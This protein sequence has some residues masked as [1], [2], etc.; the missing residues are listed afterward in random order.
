[1]GVSLVLHVLGS[2]V[3]I[4]SVC[5]SVLPVAVVDAVKLDG[6]VVS[7][8]LDVLGST[9]DFNA[10]S[11]GLSIS[12]V[13]SVVLDDSSVSFEP[14]VVRSSV[15][16]NIVCV[17]VQ[18]IFTVDSLILDVVVES[19]VLDFLGS[20]VVIDIVCVSGFPAVCVSV[21]KDIFGLKGEFDAVGW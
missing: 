1:M 12:V 19:G 2:S 16:I 18:P 8:A 17:S 7:F 20:T 15:E 11:V 5:V 3:I 6:V 4:G 13:E 21:V 10:A 14:D 9:V